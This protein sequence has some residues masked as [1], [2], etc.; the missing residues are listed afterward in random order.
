MKALLCKSFGTPDSLVIEDLPPTSPAK[1]EVKIQI[2]AA[3]VNFPDVLMIQGKY[4]FKPDMPFSPGGECAGEILEIGEDVQGFKVGD[5]VI[6]VTGFGGFREELNVKSERLFKMPAK[7]DYN[8]AA[9]FVMTYGTSYHALVQRAQLKAGETLLVLGAAGGV[10]L[11]AVEIGKNLGATVIAAAST[12]EKLEVCK[13]A[14]ADRLINYSDG[15]ELK[16]QI[17]ALTGGRGA[18]V[19]YDP[20]GGDLFDQSLRCINFNGR[21]LVV[22][23]A[24]GRIP[25]IPANL[26]LLKS[27]Q[28][29]GVFWGAFT[30]KE[31]SVHL[32]NMKTLLEWFSS[33]KIKPFVSKT[34]PLENA[35]EALNAM[36]NR[37][38]TGKVVV[39]IK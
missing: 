22:G 12:N 8:T 11:A 21:I 3:S 28:I 4:Q 24:S 7:M 32:S 19:I 13:K 34:F 36:L 35:S 31:P 18:D 16:E 25:E 14:G 1:D 39:V 23:F 5:R 26:V 20:V 38:V 27:C 33:G 2:H 15:P 10:G 9:A 29:I 17:K 37:S 6:A 30:T